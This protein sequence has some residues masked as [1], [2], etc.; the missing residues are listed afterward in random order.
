MTNLLAEDLDGILARTEGMW[1]ELRGRRL[2]LT[3]GTGFFGCW[4]L[5]SFLWANDRLGLNAEV[6]ALSRRPEAFA[7]KAP[8]L[9]GHPAIRLC[10][11]D[12]RTFEF[13]EGPFSHIIH[14]ATDADAGLNLAQSLAMLDT[15]TEGT[16]RVLE[17]ARV[18]EARRFLLTSSGA[19]Y[20]RQP[21]EMSHVPE[22]YP[23]GP[24]PMGAASALWGG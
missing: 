17:F 3:G 6:V 23:G 9:S 12:V 4:L 19:V 16:R 13:P 10:Q 2:F 11:G 18:C 14:A 15:I 1:E 5:E 21:L 20:G 24:D 7:R 8:H 22:E